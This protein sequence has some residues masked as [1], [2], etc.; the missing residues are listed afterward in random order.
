MRQRVTA[1]RKK[2]LFYLINTALPLTAG[3]IIYLFCYKG[4][5]INTVFSQLFEFE[6]P[7][8]HGYNFIYRFITCWACDILWAYSLT[9]SLH[10]CFK[11]FKNSLLISVVFS[12]LL[13]IIIEI[14]QL[15]GVIRGTFDLLDIIFEISAIGFAVI[16][17]KRS[18]SK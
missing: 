6:L 10:F 15:L 18:F 7:Y 16:I 2:I 1:V 4:T 5:Y 11:D 17:I 13:A 8:F 9:F 12:A 3:L 14:L